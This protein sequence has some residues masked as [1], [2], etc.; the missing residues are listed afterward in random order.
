MLEAQNASPTKR[1]AEAKEVGDFL[2]VLGFAE[3]PIQTFNKCMFVFVF[4]LG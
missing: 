4:A 3:D 2:K 1:L